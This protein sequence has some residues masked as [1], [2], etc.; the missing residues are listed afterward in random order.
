MAAACTIQ[1]CVSLC[2]LWISH[3]V[4][5]LVVWWSI[6]Y[7]CLYVGPSVWFLFFRCTTYTFATFLE[8]KNRRHMVNYPTGV[9]NNCMLVLSVVRILPLWILLTHLTLDKMAAI[10]QTT[11]SGN[12]MAPN[13]WQAIT[14][15]K[16]VLV[17][18]HTCICGT[19]VRLIKYA[20]KWDS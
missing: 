16:A 19:R 7:V 10:S 11:Y 2:V 9:L 15:T 18:R 12:G 17:D 20:L 5:K 3:T 6:S 1:T 4:V 14:W 8:I 13:R